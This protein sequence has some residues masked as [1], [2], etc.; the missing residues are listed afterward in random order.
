MYCSL[1]FSVEDVFCVT[2][3]TQKEN[4]NLNDKPIQVRGRKHL[5]VMKPEMPK[6]CNTIMNK[7]SVYSCEQIVLQ[8]SK[9]YILPVSTIF[10]NDSQ[11]VNIT[12]LPLP[13]KLHYH[14]IIS[15]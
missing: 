3:I 7:S 8:A 10:S 1:K 12:T 11:N 2:Y 6:K 14:Q 13:L 15:P 9:F 4:C 5:E